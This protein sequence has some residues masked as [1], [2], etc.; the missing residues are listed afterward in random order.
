MFTLLFAIYHGSKSIPVISGKV[1][2][3]LF[4]K[5]VEGL[6]LQAAE[7]HCAPLLY[8]RNQPPGRFECAK[9]KS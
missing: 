3:I 8:V 9:G 4:E 5:V 1:E 6:V 7:S 2:R